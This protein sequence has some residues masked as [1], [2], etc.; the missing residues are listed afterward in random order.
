MSLARVPLAA[1]PLRGM[2]P[3]LFLTPALAALLAFFALPVGA[4]FL[5]SLTDFDLYALADA[6]NLRFVGIDQLELPTVTGPADER[7]R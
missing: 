7:L 6:D 2:A 3:L 1:R 5:L 4:A